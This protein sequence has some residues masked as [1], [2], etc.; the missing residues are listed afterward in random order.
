MPREVALRQPAVKF[1]H[2]DDV[3]AA[4]AQMGKH[5]AQELRRDFEVAVG[6][7]GGVSCRA[8]VVE[9]E[10]AA[11]AGKNRA[12][13]AVHAGETKRFQAGADDGAA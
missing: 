9:H 5:R 12:K 2:S 11:R 13:Q 6:L 10:N 8:H 3:D 1:I 7:K 4:R